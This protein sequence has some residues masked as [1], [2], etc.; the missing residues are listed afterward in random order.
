MTLYLRRC[1]GRKSFKWLAITERFISI[2]ESFSP[3]G[4]YSCEQLDA[5]SYTDY[6]QFWR[7]W[8]GL[9]HL[10]RQSVYLF[11]V[12]NVATEPYNGSTSETQAVMCF[13]YSVTS[14]L[15]LYH[16]S[17]DIL[18]WDPLMW[19]NVIARGSLWFMGVCNKLLNLR[20][21]VGFLTEDKNDIIIETQW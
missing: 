7:L 13:I 21:F 1:K 15:L 20:V 6:Q 2:S 14:Q 12:V 16:I 9:H 11:T 10:Y 18:W 17:R 8:E 5:R 4:A 3:C 19:D